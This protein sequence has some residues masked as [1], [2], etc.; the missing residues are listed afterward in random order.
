MI[1][2]APLERATDAL[3]W[4]CAE[5]REMESFAPVQYRWEVRE[6]TVTHLPLTSASSIGIISFVLTGFWRFNAKTGKHHTGFS[7]LSGFGK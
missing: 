3:Y 2:T 5:T 7:Q 4:S 1:P 6:T